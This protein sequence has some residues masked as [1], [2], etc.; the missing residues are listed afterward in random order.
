MKTKIITTTII[1]I[2][3]ILILLSLSIKTFTYNGPV[4]GG[5]SYTLTGDSG[6]LN[7]P[8][9]NAVI[10]DNLNIPIKTNDLI[11]FYFSNARIANGVGNGIGKQQVYYLG[12]ANVVGSTYTFTGYASDR[13]ASIK[14]DTSVPTCPAII[15]TL[16][17][18]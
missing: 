14:A 5:R 15:C 2:L 16:E 17:V 13:I 9:L 18:I 6:L 8:Y 3:T 4:T 10:F 11:G 1:V 7:V 12:D